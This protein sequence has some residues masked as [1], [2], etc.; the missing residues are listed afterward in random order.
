MKRACVIGWPVAC[1]RSPLIHGY[2]LRKYRIDGSYTKESVRPE[3]FMSFI[4]SLAPRGFAGCNVTIPYKEVAFAAAKISDH[5]AAAVGAANTLWFEDGA[6]A[7]A[8]TDICGF[9]ANLDRSAPQR[10]DMASPVLVLGAGGSARAVIYGLLNRGWS[11][12]RIFNRMIERAEGVARHFGV[13]VSA[14][15]WN[16]RND[17]VP[18]VSLIVNTTTLG[19][20]GAGDP[21]IDFRS[22]KKDAIV[23]DLVYIPLETPLLKSARTHGL[24]GIDGL[25]MLIHQAA[26]GFEKW[27]GVRPDISPE[28]FTLVSEN[29][30]EYNECSL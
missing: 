12:I 28:L 11:D 24:V 14:W 19:M 4:M 1:S 2:W 20:N 3:D 26:P 30:R 15:P 10:L 9:M 23:V 29:I 8:N 22:A 25:G 7:C 27:F 13:G 5:S 18:H 17:H 21:D 16:V 6:L